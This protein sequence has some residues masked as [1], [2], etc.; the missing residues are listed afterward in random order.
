MFIG[1]NLGIEISGKD[2]RIAVIRSA[3]RRLRLAQVL[4]IAGFAD[5]APAE[6]KTAL[7][8]LVKQDKL[9]PNRVFLTL[10]RDRG[11]ARQIELPSEIRDKVKSAGALQVV[12]LCRW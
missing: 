4:E 5:L 8:K 12:T 10:P 6:Q 7:Q 11:I 3:I 9:S 2:L 1:T